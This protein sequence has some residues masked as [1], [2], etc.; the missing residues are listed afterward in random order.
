MTYRQP[1][2]QTADTW[3]DTLADFLRFQH[4]DL[5]VDMLEPTDSRGYW[6]VIGGCKGGDQCTHA[7]RGVL[8]ACDGG[9]ELTVSFNEIGKRHPNG[10]YVRPFRVW[11]AARAEA[12]ADAKF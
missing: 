10:R 6:R 8:P 1:D 7:W 5:T 2:Y 4:P 12:I 11:E 9:V 3:R